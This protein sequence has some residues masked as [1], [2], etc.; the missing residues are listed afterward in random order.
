MMC[1]AACSRWLSANQVY[2]NTDLTWY[3]A[4]YE[5]AAAVVVYAPELLPPSI[6]A[7]EPGLVA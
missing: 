7:S 5:V 3:Q 4:K 1:D 2:Y 6:D